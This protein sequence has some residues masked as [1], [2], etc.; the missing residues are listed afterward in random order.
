MDQ[1]E[2][3]FDVRLD[4]DAAKEYQKIKQPDLSIVDKSIDELMIRADEVGK[5]LGNKRGMNLA[6]CKEIK[7]RDAGIRI[8]FR[9]TN[10]TVEVLRVVYIL[11]IE[12]R[13][14]DFVFKIASA[15]LKLVKDKKVLLQTLK[16]SKKF[17]KKER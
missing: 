2:V 8:V 10:E 1:N 6:G 12:K 17:A 13:S 15:R 5:P 11:A 4:K 16:E 7:L 9:V 14:R 3:K